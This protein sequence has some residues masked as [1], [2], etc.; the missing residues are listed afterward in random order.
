MSDEVTKSSHRLARRA[1][2]MLLCA[3]GVCMT[4]HAAN[5]ATDVLP[6]PGPERKVSI[7]AVRDA[8]LPNGLRVVVVNR[9]VTPLVSVALYLR[10]GAEVDPPQLAGLT[11]L[12][13]GLLDK[14]TTTRTAPQIAEAADA[15]GGSLG[16]GAGFDVSQ[17]TCS[18]T[19][20]VIRRSRRRRS[21]ANAS[22]CSTTFGLR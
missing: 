10:S 3:A 15:L 19:W 22:R 1:A 13:A 12:T 11:D 18:P 17:A 2:A 21:I 5:V 9:A 20:C 8:T 7:P 16:T 4:A 14:G 6:E